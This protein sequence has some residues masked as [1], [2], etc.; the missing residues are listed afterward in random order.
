MQTASL[1]KKTSNMKKQI[2]IMLVSKRNMW[3]SCQ[4]SCCHKSSA[5]WRWITI[6][7]IALGTILSL[8]HY[9]C[10]QN[11]KLKAFMSLQMGKMSKLNLICRYCTNAKWST[12]RMTNYHNLRS[13]LFFMSVAACW[14]SMSLLFEKKG[15]SIC[16]I[17]MKLY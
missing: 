13:Y 14:A 2:K 11:Q 1:T 4:C 10:H 9:T 8:G 3:Q 15:K 6:D 16:L 17:A 5:N 7:E 12:I